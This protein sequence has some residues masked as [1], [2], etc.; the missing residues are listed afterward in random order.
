MRFNGTHWDSKGF[1][2]KKHKHNSLDGNWGLNM[3]IMSKWGLT[4]P[5]IHGIS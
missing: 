1:N 2:G 3:K 4:K 5:I